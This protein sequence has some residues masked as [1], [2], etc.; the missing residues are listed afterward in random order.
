MKQV[1]MSFEGELEGQDDLL[2][3]IEG[4][5]FDWSPGKEMRSTYHPQ[6]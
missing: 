6:V 4:K 5:G 3:L 2:A 1:L